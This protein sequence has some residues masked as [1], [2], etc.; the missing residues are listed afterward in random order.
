MGGKCFAEKK[1]ALNPEIFQLA[2]SNLHKRY[3]VGK[4]SQIIVLA[5]LKKTNQMA[6]I[7]HIHVKW[8]YIS[9]NVAP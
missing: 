6:A 5:Y 9:P 7:S 4:A 1:G 2:S 3:T 8:V